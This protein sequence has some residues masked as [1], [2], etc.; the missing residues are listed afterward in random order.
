MFAFR[1]IG[2]KAARRAQS[3]RPLSSS[4]RK[5]NGLNRQLSTPALFKKDSVQLQ[6]DGAAINKVEKLK[7]VKPERKTSLRRVGLEAERSRVVVRHKGGV[8][9][10][11]HGV[12]TKVR[13]STVQVTTIPWLT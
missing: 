6:Q 13:C 10:L 7:N 8:R 12:E 5:P 4:L 9:T 11:E 1:G 2:V 3:F